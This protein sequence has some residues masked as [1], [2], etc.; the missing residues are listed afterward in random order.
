MLLDSADSALEGLWGGLGQPSV[1]GVV[2]A[3]VAAPSLELVRNAE[4]QA[5]PPA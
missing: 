2:S 4:S 5:P 1:L 3:P